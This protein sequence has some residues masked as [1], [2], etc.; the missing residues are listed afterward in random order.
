M[1]EQPELIKSLLLGRLPA[2]EAPGEPRP[3]HRI[4]HWKDWHQLPE[5]WV[6]HLDQARI[7][8]VSSNPSIGGK[9]PA[10]FA[11]ATPP[12]HL[13]TARSKNEKI[14]HRFEWAFDDYMID[15][16]RH[17]DEK[18]AVRYW[19]SVKLR[20][21]ELLPK[22]DLRPGWDY[23]SRKSCGASHSPR[24]EWQSRRQCVN[25]YLASTLGA[26]P[27]IVDTSLSVRT[28][29]GRLGRC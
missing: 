7:L 17:L 5:P 9:V 29:A 14:I 11:T 8:F 26:G 16:V 20:A 2:V 1:L 13:V 3:Q 12:T 28:L 23:A 15:G 22:G 21:K 27:A 19:S 24:R 10:D 6:G 4:R 18:K 25:R